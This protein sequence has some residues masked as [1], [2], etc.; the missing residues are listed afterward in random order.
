MKITTYK[1]A[2][3]VLTLGLTISVLCSAQS[4]GPNN[5]DTVINNPLMG[6]AVW[7]NPLNSLDSNK[8]YATDSLYS[9]EMR[10]QFLEATG[11]NFSIPGTATILG[12]TIRVYG[13]DS[14]KGLASITNYLR[15]VKNNVLQTDSLPGSGIGA[16]PDRWQT[17]GGCA[18]LWNNTWT[19]ADINAAGFGA[20]YDVS[21]SFLI[22]TGF[23]KVSIDVIEATVCYSTPLSA[24]TL[25]Q[26][27]T[28][29]NV[30]PNPTRGIV[31]LPYTGKYIL[32]LY[33]LTGKEVFN[34]DMLGAQQ[35]DLSFLP[36]GIY[37]FHAYSDSYNIT[38]K[39]VIHK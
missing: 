29:A 4:Q 16:G 17:I 33:D 19:P 11:F 6:K 3:V 39:L 31:E 12:I 8:I 22:L 32:T 37:M 23:A 2:F 5:P 13:H 7:K 14:S 28:A 26:T 24:E 18:N 36:D 35:L 30:Y 27:R 34:S 21:A 25:S 15:L 20:A 10:S 38:R 9:A 1:K